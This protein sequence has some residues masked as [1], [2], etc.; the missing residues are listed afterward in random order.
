MQISVFLALSLVMVASAM[1]DDQ[2]QTETNDGFAMGNTQFNQDKNSTGDDN[3]N[4]SDEG[5]DPIEAYLEDL[6]G[7]MESN[8]ELDTTTPIL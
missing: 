1:C 5:C 8:D 3:A 4:T 6:F 7:G 2:P